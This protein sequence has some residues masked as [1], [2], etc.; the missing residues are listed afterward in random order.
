MQR[1][2]IPLLLVS[3]KLQDPSPDPEQ[4]ACD[5]VPDAENAQRKREK[6]RW[7]LL[8]EHAYRIRTE[9]FQR[10]RPLDSGALVARWFNCDGQ[11]IEDIAKRFD[12]PASRLRKRKERAVAFFQPCHLVP[13]RQELGREICDGTQPC[14]HDHGRGVEQQ[15]T[16][17]CAE[18]I[19]KAAVEGK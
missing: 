13:D 4:Q 11:E 2:T 6:E 18:R 15:Y 14:V 10:L 12:M 9:E 5:N 1:R 17:S 16:Q 7:G 8:S 19:I 3:H